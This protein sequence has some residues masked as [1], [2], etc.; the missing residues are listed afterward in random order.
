MLKKKAGNTL[1]C[2]NLVAALCNLYA[3]NYVWSQIEQLWGLFQHTKQ[4]LCAGALR[5]LLR[6]FS[7]A[8]LK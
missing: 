4:F 3:L 6:C 2:N 8:T 5:L 7:F 1:D